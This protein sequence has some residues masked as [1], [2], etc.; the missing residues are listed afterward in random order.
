MGSILPYKHGVGI[1]GERAGRF[2][3]WFEF[4]ETV[5]VLP[6]VIAVPYCILYTDSHLSALSTVR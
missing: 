2:E 1:S 4:E 6:C 3:S 5:S